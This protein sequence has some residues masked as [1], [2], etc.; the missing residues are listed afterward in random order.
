MKKKKMLFFFF[1]LSLSI[2]LLFF[3]HQQKEQERNRDTKKIK[4]NKYNNFFLFTF[5]TENIFFN[6]SLLVLRS[7]IHS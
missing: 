2:S 7:T 4:N 5:Q 1:S 3:L 6:T